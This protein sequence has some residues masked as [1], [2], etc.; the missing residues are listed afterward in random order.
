MA[1]GRTRS[2]RCAPWSPQRPSVFFSSSQIRT[3]SCLPQFLEELRALEPKPSVLLYDPFLPM[4]LVAAKVLSIPAVATLTMTGPGVVQVAP[5]V[6]QRWE[7]S[8]V[9][10]AA[11]R[12]VLEAYGVDVFQQGGWEID[13]NEAFRGGFEA[14]KGVKRGE[15]C[16]FRPVRDVYGVLLPRLEPGEHQQV[17]LRGAQHSHAAR[18]LPRLP[19]RASPQAFRT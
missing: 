10:R 1:L 5:F 17:A 11:H 4:G 14:P 9:A 6:Q 16:G 15:T 8:G 3:R 7:S 12:E 19:F 13:G 18:A 2:S